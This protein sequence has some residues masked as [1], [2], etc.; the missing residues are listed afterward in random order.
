MVLGKYC[1]GSG[2]GGGGGGNILILDLD[3]GSM[4]IK[5]YM[6]TFLHVVI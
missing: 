1:F 2:L 5:I 6:C 3:G 4:V